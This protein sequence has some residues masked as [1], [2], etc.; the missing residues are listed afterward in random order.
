M[1][2]VYIRGAK[3]FRGYALSL[4]SRHSHARKKQKSRFKFRKVGEMPDIEI[5]KRPESFTG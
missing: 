1:L 3:I 2:K 5:F 4:K